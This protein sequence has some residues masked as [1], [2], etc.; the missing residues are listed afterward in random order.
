MQE[1]Q[2]LEDAVYSEEA[3][4]ELL[5]IG[6]KTLDNLRLEKAFP[7]VRLTIKARVYLAKDVLAWLE[8]RVSVF[9]K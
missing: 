3:M 9:A 6:K 7:A 2:R 5:G 8:S 1:P 4:L